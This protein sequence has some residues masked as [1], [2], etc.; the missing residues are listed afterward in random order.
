MYRSEQYRETLNRQDFPEVAKKFLAYAHASSPSDP[1][2]VGPAFLCAAWVC[3]DAGR[4]EQAA[5]SRKLAADWL[6]RCKPFADKKADVATGAILV[7][8]LR[9]CGRFT[10]ASSECAA[11]LVLPGV[12]GVLRQVLQF[13]ERLIGKADQSAHQ[14]S[15]SRELP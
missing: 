9:R 12:T 8:V 11:L 13:Q 14:V 2:A 3:D 5:E 6:R 7:D 1:A 4:V 10:E 15:D